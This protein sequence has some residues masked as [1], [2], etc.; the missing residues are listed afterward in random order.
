MATYTSQ[1]DGA[2]GNDTYIISDNPTTNYGTNTSMNI[3]F[4]TGGGGAGRAL[5][6]FD[7]SS[8]PATATITS[9]ILTLTPVTDNSS[10]ARTLSVYRCL[11]AWTEAG[12]T[13]NKYD[14]TNNWGTAGAENTTSDRESTAIGT[15][16]VSASETLN[17]GKDI[18]LDAS[19]MQEF[20]TGALANNGFVLRVNTESNDG[21]NWA[22]SDHVTAAYRPKLV[23]EY[24]YGGNVII[25]SS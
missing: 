18:T 22:S 11:R 7:L 15:L 6:K 3:G 13:W 1:P 4:D 16:S 23:I 14:G 9:A 17:V 10:N 5:I 19:K 20:I 21:Y 25:W 8:I 24:L 2:S 12:A